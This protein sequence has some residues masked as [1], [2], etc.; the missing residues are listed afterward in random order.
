MRRGAFSEDS[1]AADWR[2][3]SIQDTQPRLIGPDWLH[4]DWNYHSHIHGLPYVVL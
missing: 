1:A 4:A 2:T 3:V